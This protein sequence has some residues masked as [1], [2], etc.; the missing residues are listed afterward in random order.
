MGISKVYVFDSWNHESMLLTFVHAKFNVLIDQTGHP[1]LSG[2]G[3]VAF[4]SDLLNGLSSSSHNHGGTL[5]WM[6]PE[7]IVPEK[8]G[9]TNTRPT[10]HSDCY[11]L[12]MVIY[13]I[14]SGHLPFHKDTHL[15]VV[16]KISEGKHPPRGTQFTDSLWEMLEWCW[17]PRPNARPSIGEILQCLETGLPSTRKY[18]ETEE[19]S[20]DV[21]TETDSDDMETEWGGEDVEMEEGTD[22]RGS[23]DDSPCR[24]SR[25][26][27]FSP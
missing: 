11:A 14:I 1:R 27:P 22:G 25:P 24:V 26:P 7:L 19:D 15:R 3:L 20:N 16:I 2:F 5:R 13:E 23:S 9:F 12:G 4:T 8:F 17:E 6:S 21:E 18:V 10:I